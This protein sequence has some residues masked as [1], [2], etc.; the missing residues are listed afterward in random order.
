[1]EKTTIIPM[2]RFGKLWKTFKIIATKDLGDG[3][4]LIASITQS[5]EID[6]SDETRYI[7]VIYRGEY[8]RYG[9]IGNHKLLKRETFGYLLDAITF[10][11]T[12]DLGD[13]ETTNE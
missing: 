13:L 2:E 9:M 5:M 6:Y 7:T 4:C 3:T 11:E 1:M 8:N 10:C 12:V